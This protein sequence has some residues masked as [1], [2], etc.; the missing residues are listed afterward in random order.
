MLYFIVNM[1]NK[2]VEWL[3]DWGY[4]NLQKGLGNVADDF[5]F[6]LHLINQ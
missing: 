1:W 4:M 6:T 3:K 5:N 2:Y